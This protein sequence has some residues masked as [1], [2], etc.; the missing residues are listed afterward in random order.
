VHIGSPEGAKFPGGDV[1]SITGQSAWGEIQEFFE[2][3]WA[4]AM[5]QGQ[6]CIRLEEVRR[7]GP[8][9]WIPQ[10]IRYAGFKQVDGSIVG[11]PKNQALTQ[12]IEQLGWIFKMQGPFEVLPL[13]IQMPGQ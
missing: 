1:R 6:L 13:I 7:P 10:L 5:P 8:R 2:L 9:V 12:A 4:E 3:H 11:D